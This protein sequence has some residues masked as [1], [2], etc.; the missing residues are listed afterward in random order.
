MAQVTLDNLGK[1]YPGSRRHAPVRALDSLSL[2]AADGEYLVLVG[3]SG[4][5][6]TTALRLIAGLEDPTSGSI[7]IAGQ[8]A[9]SLSPAGRDVA[10]VFQSYSLY[11]HMTAYENMA[12][13]PRLRGEPRRDIDARVREAARAL[14]VE[15]A[16]HRRPGQLSGGQCQRI[17]LAR[18]LVRRPRALLLDEP[19]SNLDAPLRAAA[20]ADLK[21]LHRRDPTTTLHVTHDQGEAM[22]LGDRVAV[23]SPAR[24]EQAGTPMSLHREPAS[25]FV[26]GF[27]GTPAMSFVEGR[28]ERAGGLWFVE[29][30][31][32]GAR[33]AI[34]AGHEGRFEGA[35]GPPVVLGFRARVPADGVPDAA[36]MPLSFLVRTVEPLGDD[37]EVRGETGAG[38]PIVA[39]VPAW[40]GVAP[41]RSLMVEVD[42][43][44]AHL[45]EP[46]P[47]GR[48]LTGGSP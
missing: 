42:P 25:R 10:M 38:S 29:S 6:K 3:P 4:C 26:A 35:V 47:F 19:L 30:G 34:P 41:G 22:A 12:F 13:A 37:A 18:C 33:L 17:A 39:R 24:L 1:V 32:G 11:P 40:E 14:G 15:D 44:A 27:I 16:L 23:M 2:D 46:G 5:G 48:R 8:A 43:R 45:F 28:L 36:R 9:E 7:R 20:R 21:A 31:E